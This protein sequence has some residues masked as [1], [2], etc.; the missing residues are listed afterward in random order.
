MKKKSFLALI[1]ALTLLVSIAFTGCEATGDSQTE[2]TTPTTGPD[3]TLSTESVD[4][5]PD[6]QISHSIDHTVNAITDMGRVSALVEKALESGKLTITVGDMLSNTLYVDSS[7]DAF[8]NKFYM[9]EYDDEKITLDIYGKGK[10]YAVESNL[11][12]D[13]VYGVDLAT[14]ATDLPNSV[15]WKII[16]VD[17]DTCMSQY[18]EAFEDLYGLVEIFEDERFSKATRSLAESVETILENVER[19]TS[20]ESVDIHGTEVDAITVTYH[21]TGD[22]MQDVVDAYI[23]YMEDITMIIADKIDGF[24]TEDTAISPH[25]I[26]DMYDEIHMSADDLFS[27]YEMEA[28]LTIAI[29]PKNQYVMSVTAKITVFSEDWDVDRDDIDSSFAS[30]SV[31]AASGDVTYEGEP[32]DIQMELTLGEDPSKSDHYSLALNMSM[33]DETVCIDADLKTETSDGHDKTEL[34]FSV[35]EGQETNDL[36]IRFDHDTQASTYSA[37]VTVDGEEL[38]SMNGEYELT[39]TR[40]VF[41]VDSVMADGHE[42]EVGF[43]LEVEVTDNMDIPEMPEYTN[44]LTMSEEEWY[45]LITLFELDPTDGDVDDMPITTPCY[46]DVYYPDDPNLSHDY[47]DGCKSD[48]V[49]DDLDCWD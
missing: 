23:D 39:D 2:D 44:I 38:M 21:L 1:L 19:T 40:F 10:E 5:D 37:D 25:D 48:V 13:A 11:L 32:L 8:A 20:E 41:G 46:P 6:D 35:Q 45:E 22:H 18:S 17:Y 43:R 42:Q 3:T 26:S 28:D 30:D 7:K 16:G 15:I 36:V 33:G 4:K 49:E 29:S 31:I 12:G 27:G 34:R 24:T 9:C 47:S 14:A